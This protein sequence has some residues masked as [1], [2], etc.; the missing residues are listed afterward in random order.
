MAWNGRKCNR[1]IDSND[2]ICCSRIRGMIMRYGLQKNK[3]KKIILESVNR[4]PDPKYY[5]N[6]DYI[7]EL[8]LYFRDMDIHIDITE[9]IVP[10]MLLKSTERWFIWQQYR[11]NQREENCLFQKQ[12][13]CWQSCQWNTSLSFLKLQRESGGMRLHWKC[14][15]PGYA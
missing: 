9:Q 6:N 4:N 10:S 13:L 7:Y 15:E 2:S 3:L 12:S 11:K 1:T 5:I 8:L 14:Q